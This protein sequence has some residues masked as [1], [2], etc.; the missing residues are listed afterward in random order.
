[1]DVLKQQLS[2]MPHGVSTLVPGMGRVAARVAGGCRTGV[3][4]YPGGGSGS[5]SREGCEV[6]SGRAA[7]GM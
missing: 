6:R 3:A 5:G 2:R 1:M 7:A 4:G